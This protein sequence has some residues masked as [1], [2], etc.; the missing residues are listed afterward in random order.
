[1]ISVEDLCRQQLVF[2]A[3][4]QPPQPAAGVQLC[5][6][7][8]TDTYEYSKLCCIMILLYY[9]FSMSEFLPPS[10]QP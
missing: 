4:L 6:V 8:V 2:G 10:S 1:M 9:V 7:V 3:T 5:I